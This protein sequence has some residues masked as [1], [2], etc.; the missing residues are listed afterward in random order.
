[1]EGG[2]EV[3]QKK[4]FF[5]SVSDIFERNTVCMFYMCVYAYL[6]LYLSKIWNKETS[7]HL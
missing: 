1:M 7:H 6:H 2:K 3:S 5:N 4:V